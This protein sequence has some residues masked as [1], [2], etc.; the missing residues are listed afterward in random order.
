MLRAAL[1]FALLWG[2]VAPAAAQLPG[3][4][5]LVSPKSISFEIGAGKPLAYQELTVQIVALGQRP[6]RLKVTALGNLQSGE[7]DLISV[8]QVNWKGSPAS[9]FTAGT[10]IAG[11]PLLVGQ[12][13][14]SKTGVL[15]FT[16]K[17]RWDYPAGQYHL[18]LMFNLTSP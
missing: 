12:G 1:I 18:R 15:R 6:W 10:L 5:L 2:L 13:Q 3:V 17:H 16:L 9:A 4:Q 8:Q 7:G 11:Q 14:G